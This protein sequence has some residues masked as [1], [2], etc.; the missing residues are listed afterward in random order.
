MLILIAYFLFGFS[1]IGFCADPASSAAGRSPGAATLQAEVNAWSTFKSRSEASYYVS[2]AGQSLGE[3]QLGA[4]YNPFARDKWPMQFYSALY[5]GYRFAPNWTIGM[6][7][8]GAWNFASGIANQYGLVETGATLFQ[9]A[10]QLKR[11]NIVDTSWL[12]L[13][14]QVQFFLPT[15]A[16]AREKQT[17]LLSVALDNTWTIRAV[18][19]PFSVGINTKIQASFYERT[20]PEGPFAAGRETIYLSAGHFLNYTFSPHFDLQTTTLFDTNHWGGSPSL[21]DFDVATDDR[22]KVQFNW[23]PRIPVFNQAGIFVQ[24]LIFKPM[25]A[26]TIVGMDFTLRM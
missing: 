18:P 7:L 15:S 23:Y 16:F 20:V 11:A 6:E 21:S 19:Y 25:L 4:S 24:G 17:F 1:S 8:S 5:Y 9:P 10:I 2:L 3:K 22:W 13:F 12:N 14:G 26:T